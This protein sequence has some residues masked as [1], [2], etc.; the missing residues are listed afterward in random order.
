MKI[1]SIIAACLN[2]FGEPLYSEDS[3]Q[4]MNIDCQR[5][6]DRRHLLNDI[7][8]KEAIIDKGWSEKDWKSNCSFIPS[9]ELNHLRDYSTSPDLFKKCYYYVQHSPNMKFSYFKRKSARSH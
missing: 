4:Q 5:I 2:D 1:F 6:M 7:D 8:E 9:F 3:L